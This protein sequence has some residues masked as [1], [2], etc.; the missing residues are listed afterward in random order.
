[1]R[2]CTGYDPMMQFFDPW[3]IQEYIA[4]AATPSSDTVCRALRICSAAEYEPLEPEVTAAKASGPSACQ[5]VHPACRN[6]RVDKAGCRRVAHYGCA[7]GDAASP[8]S[9]SECTGAHEACKYYRN[10]RGGCARVAFYGCHWGVPIAAGVPSCQGLHSACMHQR[11][12]KAACA[13]FAHYGCVW[14]LAPPSKGVPAGASNRVCKAYR[15]APCNFATEYQANAP[16]RFSDRVCKPV[17]APCAVGE[18]EAVAPSMHNRNECR[19]CAA[20]QFQ[21]VVGQS[22]CK[23]CPPGTARTFYQAAEACTRCADGW[24]QAAP[25]QHS[26]KRNTVCTAG[27]YEMASPTPVSDR[28]CSAAVAAAA[29]SAGGWLRTATP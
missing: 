1:M 7:W 8:A 22:A 4:V 26:C 27:T 10:S 28:V 2:L 14:G 3:R 11:T 17:G 13:R 16:S 21:D 6:Y 20:G 12:D 29:T 18:Y 23:D 9:A 24:H 25:G 5:G 15:V 19:K